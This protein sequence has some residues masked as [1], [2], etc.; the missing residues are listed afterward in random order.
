[1]NTV[2]VFAANIIDNVRRAWLLEQKRNE[3][4]TVA[5]LVEGI[6]NSGMVGLCGVWSQAVGFVLVRLVGI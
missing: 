2:V 5:T 6:A 3:V 1:M 4:L